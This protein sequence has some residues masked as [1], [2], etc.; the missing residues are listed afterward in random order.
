MLFIINIIAP[1]SLL[2]GIGYWLRKSKHID[3]EFVEKSSRLVFNITLPALLF[4]TLSGQGRLAQVDWVLVFVGVLGTAIFILVYFLLTQGCK[5]P[6]SQ[7]PVLIQGAFRSNMGIVGIAYCAKAYGEE[8]LVTAAM[9]LGVVTIFYNV[10][11]ILL[12]TGTK[13]VSV[14]K[15]IKTITSNPI[16]LGILA[17]GSASLLPISIPTVIES[18]ITSLAAMTIPLALIASGGGLYFEFDRDRV[19]ALWLALLGK[20]LLYPV[21]LVS[22]GLWLKLEPVSLGIVALMASSPTAAASYVMVRKLGGDHKLA[23]QIIAFSTL[24]SLPTTA[25]LL[26]VLMH[27]NWL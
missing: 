26:A 17:G 23:A 4:S 21:L 10:V 1:V 18:V 13:S 11:S 15:L 9:Y 19:Q 7:R 12:L 5:V 8:G 22:I 3:S 2:I 25:G 6:S 14:G 24:L 27:F 16:I 20:L